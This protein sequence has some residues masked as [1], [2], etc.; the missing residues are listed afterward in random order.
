MFTRGEEAHAFAR[1]LAPRR[2]MFGATRSRPKGSAPRKRNLPPEKMFSA[3][4]S[5]PKGVEC[6]AQKE[7]SRPKGSAH[8]RS[9]IVVERRLSRVK[10]G[11]ERRQ[12]LR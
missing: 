3:T 12:V 7:L 8:A 1:A 2:I 9:E 10:D 6:P 5:R 11:D 4:R